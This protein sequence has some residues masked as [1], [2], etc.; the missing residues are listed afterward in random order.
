M[1]NFTIKGKGG[2]DFRPAFEYVNHLRARGEF[3]KLKGLLYFTDGKG[4]YPVKPQPYDVAF[5][6]V[7]EKGKNSC[8]E[9][10]VPPWAIKLVLEGE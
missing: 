6:F 8:Y 3:A 1:R 2:T 7:R 10:S 5:I 4:I 9:M